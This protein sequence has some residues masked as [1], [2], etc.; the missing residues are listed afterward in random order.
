MR[1]PTDA[2]MEIDQRICLPLTGRYLTK[3]C[4]E[5]V[6]KIVLIRYGWLSLGFQCS[7][8]ETNTKL[9]QVSNQW[10]HRGESHPLISR[11]SLNI[12]T[13]LVSREVSNTECIYSS[14]WSQYMDQ[15]EAI[16]SP[17]E[18]YF[19]ISGIGVSNYHPHH[20][21]HHVWLNLLIDKS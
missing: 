18:D 16:H 15:L 21:S 20:Q 5:R 2:I 8:Q 12:A 17:I 19:G 4:W 11:G 6:C 7:S 13:W 14:R 10:N 1:L 9:I 3:V